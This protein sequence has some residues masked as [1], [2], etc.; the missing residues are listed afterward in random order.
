ML[1]VAG[2]NR[3][4][5]I[6]DIGVWMHPTT[7]FDLICK[8]IDRTLPSTS[9]RVDRSQKLKL[10]R[11]LVELKRCVL[12]LPASCTILE[13]EDAAATSRSIGQ[14]S[15]RFTLVIGSLYLVEKCTMPWVIGE[16]NTWNCSLQRL[17]EMKHNPELVKMGSKWMYDFSNWLT[18]SV[19]EQRPLHQGRLHHRRC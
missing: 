15:A 10:G 1:V 13:Q 7:R 4:R 16:Q 12:E 17:K 2:S 8:P 11:Y 9:T 6:V 19:R 14:D 3:T 5:I 18:T